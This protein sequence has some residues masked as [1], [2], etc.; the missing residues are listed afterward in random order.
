MP[1]V[2]NCLFCKESFS[3]K[4]SK[5]RKYC[6]MS[7]LKKEGENKRTFSC[8]ECK[9]VFIIPVATIK[10]NDRPFCSKEC[11]NKF[12][13]GENNP[14]WKGVKEDFTCKQCNSLFEVKHTRRKETA[15][16]CSYKCR[17]LFYDVH[18]TPNDEKIYDLCVSC[19]S[20]IKI[21]KEKLGKRNFCDKDCADLGQSLYLRG[22]KNGRYIDGSYKSIYEA[23][24][25]KKLKNEIREKYDLTCQICGDIQSIGNTLHVHHIDGK[26]DNHSP[27]NLISLCKRCHRKTHGA[28]VKDI[29]KEKLSN[30]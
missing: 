8:T 11:W 3:S 5:N 16:F 26:K 14:S 13:I 7:C 29:W 24:W 28:K 17:T 6:S 23:G 25:T 20:K 12:Q 9:N 2:K 4:P 1:I 27:D 21:N 22:D 18:G 30:L 19:K 10:K 15:K